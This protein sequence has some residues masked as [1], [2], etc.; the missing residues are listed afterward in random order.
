MDVQPVAEHVPHDQKVGVLALH[1]HAVHGQELG[2]HGVAVAGDDVLPGDT[3]S[4]S[5]TA[6]VQELLCRVASF[7]CS[8]AISIPTTIARSVLTA[9]S[10]SV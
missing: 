1:A 10:L 4:A 6:H 2:Q 8:A 9:S 7:P 5:L 3:E